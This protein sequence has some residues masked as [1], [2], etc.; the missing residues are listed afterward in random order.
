MQFIYVS[1]L[2][3]LIIKI[4]P[5]LVNDKTGFTVLEVMKDHI[6]NMLT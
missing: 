2:E 1:L 3:L 5:K 6:K 4:M